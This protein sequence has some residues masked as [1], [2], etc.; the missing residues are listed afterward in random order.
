MIKDIRIGDLILNFDGNQFEVK[1][2][3]NDLIKAICC[4]SDGMKFK[5]GEKIV[6]PNDTIH[7]ILHKN[8]E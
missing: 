8:K 7:T 5:I 4:H 6:I 1:E 2:I 3:E